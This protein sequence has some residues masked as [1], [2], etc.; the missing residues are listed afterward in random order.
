M[1]NFNSNIH[2]H[3]A[4]TERP[5][6]SGE[7]LVIHRYSR[8]FSVS[9]CAYSSNWDKFNVRDYYEFEQILK[10]ELDNISHWAYLE[11]INYEQSADDKEV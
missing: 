4:T 5:P 10:Y 9:N 7:Y 6:C 1:S 11:D 3:D 8:G 2:W